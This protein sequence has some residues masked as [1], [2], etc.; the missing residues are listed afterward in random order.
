MKNLKSRLFDIIFGSETKAGKTFDIILLIII[1]LSVL[2]VVLESVPDIRDNHHMLLYTI[3]WVFTIIFSIEYIL[4]VIISPKKFKYIFSFYGLIDFV[5][6]LP[7]FIAI[8]VTGAHSLIIIRAFRLLRVFRIL[9][10]SRYTSAGQSLTK[11]LQASRAKISVFLFAVFTVVLF[12]GTL[13]Y[14]IEGEENGFTSIPKGIYWAIVTITTVGYG[15]LTP[16]TT[17][18]QFI[19]SVLMILGYAIIAVPTGIISV[20]MS[21]LSKN[22]QVCQSC[23]N[24][25]HDDDATFCKNC[26]KKIKS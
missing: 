6:I 22:T 3:E 17:I 12:M 19:S 20:E 26:G 4:R 18:G 9:K 10:I 21:R 2:V 23:F 5:A 13:M 8:I 14:L 1:C 11:A 25:D 16:I 7:T 15:D 24:D